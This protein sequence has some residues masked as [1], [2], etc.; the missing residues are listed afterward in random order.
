[1]KLVFV[2]GVGNRREGREAAFDQSVAKRDALFRQFVVGAD[3]VIL[4]PYWGRFGGNARWG[5]ESVP[6]AG[7][8]EFADERTSDRLLSLAKLGDGT[9][10]ERLGDLLVATMATDMDP[11]DYATFAAAVTGYLSRADLGWAADLASDQELAV[12]LAD[13]VAGYAAG[14]QFGLGDLWDWVRQ[15]VDRLIR[16]AANH[17]SDAA[18]LRFKP[19]IAQA[20]VRLIGDLCAYLDMRSPLRPNPIASAVLD[21]LAQAWESKQPGE[22]LVV[23]AH[24]FGGDIVYDVLTAFAD[25]LPSN[26]RIDACVTVGSQVGLF[27]ELDNHQKKI[28]DF[29]I[30]PPQRLPMP[31]GVARWINVFDYADPFAFR[32]SDVFE[33]VVDVQFDTGAPL[34]AAH[35]AYFD[36]PSFYTRLAARL[37]SMG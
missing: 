33:G 37:K 2:H 18:M 26:F 17:A 21:A 28:S 12:P 36:R 10:R 7:Q 9:A 1:V 31:A 30:T 14:A 27:Q 13:G 34:W 11:E 35:N 15:A 4:N 29:G 16:G 23:V 25:R 5:L 24:S 19:Q 32:A 20:G 8:V 6:K 3:G 22:P